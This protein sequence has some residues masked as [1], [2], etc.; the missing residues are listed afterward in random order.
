MEFEVLGI[1]RLR[2]LV[3]T[4]IN[5]T[6]PETKYHIWASFHRLSLLPEYHSF[7]LHL[8]GQIFQI[9]HSEEMSSIIPLWP[10]FSSWAEI[11]PFSN[12]MTIINPSDIY[13]NYWVV[14]G[15]GFGQLFL[16]F[17][18]LVLDIPLYRRVFVLSLYLDCGNTGKWKQRLRWLPYYYKCFSL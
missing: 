10:L 9:A 12:M 13:L 3:T 2:L 15:K 11:C 4:L 5:S 6:F 17:P 7:P 18:F 16:S 14:I 8:W 1:H